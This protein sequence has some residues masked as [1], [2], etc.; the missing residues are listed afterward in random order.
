MGRSDSKNSL[1]KGCWH[2]HCWSEAY[3]N[4]SIEMSGNGQMAFKNWIYWLFLLFS[5]IY[6]SIYLSI[7]V[8]RG[9]KMSLFTLVFYLTGN[10]LIT[11]KT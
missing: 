5:D 7:L 10:K 1:E 3:H 8:L 6:L 2:D 11:E 4:I 9:V